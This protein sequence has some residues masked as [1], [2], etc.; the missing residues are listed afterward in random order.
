MDLQK[1]AE[2]YNETK[3]AELA[4]A[5]ARV[6]PLNWKDPINVTLLDVTIEE[7]GVIKEAITFYTGGISHPSIMVNRGNGRFHV[8]ITAPGY[9]ASIGA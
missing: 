2:Y 8:W 4:A 9:Y 3:V 5:F 1:F 7:I 6:T